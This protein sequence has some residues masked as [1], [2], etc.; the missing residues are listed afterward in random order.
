M[1]EICLFV[2]CKWYK[3]C[4]SAHKTNNQTVTEGQEK[5]CPN[6]LLLEGELDLQALQYPPIAKTEHQGQCL[7]HF[8]SNYL[9]L[10]YL[11]NNLTLRVEIDIIIGQYKL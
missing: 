4:E 7:K 10:F 2:N 5:K 6:P 9:I 8:F 3:W 11:G 1:C